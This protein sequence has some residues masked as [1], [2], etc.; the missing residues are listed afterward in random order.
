ML[1]PPPAC[2]PAKSWA[3]IVSGKAPGF[4]IA[5]SLRASTS[6]RK[7]LRLTNGFHALGLFALRVEVACALQSRTGFTRLIGPGTRF[8]GT[9]LCG[10]GLAL[11]LATH[12]FGGSRL[13]LSLPP[14]D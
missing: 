13:S 11:G 2:R 7:C 1:P 8:G 14:H 4:L 9:L 10:G 3:H 12:I 6:H 5:G